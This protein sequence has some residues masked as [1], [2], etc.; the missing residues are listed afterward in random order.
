[1]SGG[2]RYEA[3]KAHITAGISSGL[4]PPGSRL[5]SEHALVEA[6][7]VS[8]MTVNR[9]LRELARDGLV[10]RTQGVGSFVAEARALPSLAEVR[11]IRATIAERGGRHTCRTVVAERRRAGEEA[12]LLGLS[13]A[14]E[15]LHVHLVHH[16]DGVPL[17]IERRFVRA[18][19][20][21]DLLEVDFSAEPMADYLQ[22]F[23]PVSELEHVVEARLADAAEQRDLGLAPGA[24]VL[25]IRRRTWVGARI[26]TLGW[27]S[28]PGE[29]Y[30][31]QVRI[32]PSDFAAGGGG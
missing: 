28:Q 32:R 23:A 19:F 27:F 5:P 30:R 20:A 18:D 24:P 11:D 29:R 16:E 9:A 7:S 13:P 8:R 12:A 22:R 10:T 26:V 31:V 21:P 3:V 4:Y 6:L 15:L 17:Q 25:R 14:E 2:T 1:M